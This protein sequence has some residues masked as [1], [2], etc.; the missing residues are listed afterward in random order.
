MHTLNGSHRGRC[1]WQWQVIPPAPVQATIHYISVSFSCFCCLLSISFHFRSIHHHNHP[2]SYPFFLSFCERRISLDPNSL[3][4]SFYFCIDMSRSPGSPSGQQMPR[5]LYIRSIPFSTTTGDLREL[6]SHYG[7]VKDVYIPRDFYS[8]RP[9]G[10]AYVEF[11]RSRDA[12]RVVNDRSGRLRL[13]GYELEVE[14]AQGDRKCMWFLFCLW[15]KQLR[16]IF[17]NFIFLISLKY[18]SKWD[19]SPSFWVPGSTKWPSLWTGAVSKPTFPIKICRSWI[20]WLPNSKP[21]TFPLPRE[22]SPSRFHSS[23]SH[24]ISFIWA[25]PKVSPPLLWSR[26]MNGAFLQER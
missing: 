21:F 23:F 22:N 12:D 3:S 20:T 17:S 14:F 4:G 19:E 24:S 1:R 2:L 13:F 9:R 18:S 7:E 26:I 5:S 8:R 11:Q 10:F 6:F 15:A 16:F 25:F